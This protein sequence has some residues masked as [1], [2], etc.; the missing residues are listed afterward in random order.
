MDFSRVRRSVVGGML[1]LWAAGAAS[2]CAP[3]SADDGDVTTVTVALTTVPTG[4]QCVR[5]VAT[6]TSGSATTK[7]F[8]V[9]AGSSSASLQIGPFT[10]GNYTLSGDAFNVA[11]TS[12]SGVAPWTADSVPVTVR[13]GQAATV[14][15]TFRKE[16][17]VTVNVNFVNNVLGLSMSFMNGFVVTDS[18]ILQ[19]G[20]IPGTVS[21][22]RANFAAF[23]SSSI[24]GN[25]VASI[26]ASNNAVCAIRVD[27]TIWCWGS[28]PYGETGP[29]IALGGSSSTPV[30]LTALGGATQ[31]AAGANHFCAVASNVLWCW[32]RNESG[33]LGNN[34]TA[35]STNPVRVQNIVPVRSLSLGFSSS[36]AVSTSG[37]LFAWGSNASG[38]LGDGTFVNRLI[39]TSMLESVGVISVAGGGNHACDQRADGSVHCWGQ[40]FSGQLGNGTTSA[41]SATP[42]VVSGLTAKQLVASYSS[43]CALTTSGLTQCW[44]S[45]RYGAVGDST[46]VDRTTPVSVSLGSVSLTTLVGSS[47]IDT[48]CGLSTT[49]DVWCWGE[50]NAGN[51]GDGTMNS[52]FAPVR[53]VLQ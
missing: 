23:D 47:T 42:V 53:A 7:T 4:V 25:A 24:P 14:T 13:T 2:G 11:C 32:G 3:D 22:T 16:N 19:T 34:T 1:V 52:Q 8:T 40:N 36:Y 21:Y 51:L 27:G 28:N 46:A 6:P 26:A 12:I 30:Q 45:N 20:V 5:L 43:N 17:P 35:N 44:G 18:G 29:G 31:I 38:Q 49:T 50:D 48:N 41:S 37:T 33:E 9:A 10:P 15:M 39:A